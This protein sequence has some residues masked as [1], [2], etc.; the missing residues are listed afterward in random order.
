ML[1]EGRTHKPVIEPEKCNSC[2]ICQLLCPDLAITRK[3]K[4]AVIEIDLDYCKGCGIC[5]AIC[6][7][8][9][10]KMAVESL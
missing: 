10:I 6:P 1:I 4:K 8:E 3:D 2:S 9:A 5:A 7:K